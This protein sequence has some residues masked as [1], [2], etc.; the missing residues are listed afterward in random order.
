MN[1][2]VPIKHIAGDLLLFFYDHQ[3]KNG[4]SPRS[5]V[6]FG[7]VF[8]GVINLQGKGDLDGHLFEI[9]RDNPADAYNALRYLEEK[10]FLDF[11]KSSDTGGD[12]IHGFHVT[13]HGVDIIEGI[14]RGPEERR[15]FHVTFNIKLADSINIDSL[16]KAELGNLLKGF[17]T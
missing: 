3:R 2:S 12:L 1:N 7:G 13:A 11:K 4:F 9:S 17:L 15:D 14:E 6:R 8:E 10:G 5:V 16:I